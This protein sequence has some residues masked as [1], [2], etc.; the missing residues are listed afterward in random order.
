MQISEIQQDDILIVVLV[1]RADSDGTAI[2]DEVLHSALQKGYSKIILDI[3]KL[4]YINS[5]GLR[6]FAEALKLTQAKGG[7]LYLTP[8]PPRVRRVFEIIGFD[9]FF[10]FFDNTEQ[11]LKAF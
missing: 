5:A 3:G 2:L 9:N 7:D 8:P 11:A 10:Q 4:E 1:G 6:I